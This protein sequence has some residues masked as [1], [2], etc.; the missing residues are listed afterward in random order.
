[1]DF[2]K[3]LAADLATIEPKARKLLPDGEYNAVLA[4]VEFPKY[5]KTTSEGVRFTYRITDG[6]EANQEIREDVVYMT[7]NGPL[8]FNY[9][10]IK[11]R[12]M[13]FGLTS[14]QINKFKWPANNKGFG[15]FKDVLEAN[16]TISLEQET[17]KDG[18]TRN[19]VKQVTIR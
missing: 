18:K 15:S 5:Q 8:E 12:L 4:N 14:D 2:G 3:V 10:R 16:V 17:G 6:D 9:A 19:R 11:S 1:M 13:A 7:A